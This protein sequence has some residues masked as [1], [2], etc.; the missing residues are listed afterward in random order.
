MN[1]RVSAARTSGV[2]VR[3]LAF[4][5]GSTAAARPEGAF[6]TIPNL[7]VSRGSVAVL[8]GENGC[9]KT[10]LLKLMGGMLKPHEGSIATP[11]TAPPLLVHQRPYI[12]AESV[13]ANVMWPLRIKR[14]ARHAARERA[15]AAL[16]EM[17]LTHLARRWAPSLSGGEKQRTAIARALVLDPE[18]LLLDEPTSNIDIASIAMV[19]HAIK[20]RAAGGTTIVMSTHNIGSA[21]RLGDQIIPMRAGRIEPLSVNVL[22][23]EL[24]GAGNDHIGIFRLDGGGE[25]HC[26]ALDGTFST[27]VIRMD[28]IIFSHGEIATS[29]QNRF[30]ATVVSTEHISAE[31]MR[32]TVDC[33]F[34]L[35]ALITEESARTLRIVPGAAVW[36]AFKA[37]AVRVY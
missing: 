23:G 21:Y 17:G 8:T 6:L 24:T 26:P 3:D 20:T 1:D 36:I 29:A 27:A 4:T 33:G 25:I 35:T 19:E 18:V 15:M 7:S 28:D 14:V 2:A 32:V 9:G 10:T 31:L 12:F 11:T 22:R 37:S 5:Y 34:R 16:D 30:A 13:L